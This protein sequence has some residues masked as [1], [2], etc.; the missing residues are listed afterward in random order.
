MEIILTKKQR[1]A[2]IDSIIAD[3][4]T[5]SMAALTEHVMKAYSSFQYANM[6]PILKLAIRLRKQLHGEE[7]AADMP[8]RQLAIDSDWAEF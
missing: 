5:E 3:S 2:A 1:L 6:D 8:T 4:S 7:K